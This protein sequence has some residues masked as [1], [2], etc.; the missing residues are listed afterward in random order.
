MN[1]DLLPSTDFDIIF[2]GGG[3]TACVAASRLAAADSNL[4]ILI[5]ENGHHTK[6]NPTHTQPGRY[7]HTM[8]SAVTAGTADTLTFHQGM[9]SANIDGRTPAVSS[10]KCVGGGSSINA[11][12]YNRAPA[13]DYD[14]WMHLG[15]AGWGS[16]DLIPLAKKLETYQAGVTNSTH[17][18][19]GPIKISYG[20]LETKLGKDFLVAA[21]G[22]PRGRG[23]TEDM[24]DFT[25]CDAYGRLPKYIDATT[26]RRSD[27]AHFYLYP[28]RGNPNFHVLD[29]ARV[30]RVLFNAEN[31]AIG[32]EYQ[33]ESPERAVL[34]ANAARLVVLSAGAFGSPAILER[35]GV[36]AKD[37]LEQHDITVI[38][39][40]PGVGENFNDHPAIFAPYLVPQ[41]GVTLNNLSQDTDG[42]FETQ[43]AH[44]GNGL[45]ATNGLDAGIKVR[46]NAQDLQQ[47]T[48]AFS[49]RWATFFADVPDKYVVF[50]APFSAH[51]GANSPTT[52]H[53]IFN[54][55]YFVPY[56]M[57]TG[58][59]HITSACP[60]A[61]LAVNTGLLD[62][63]EDLV[64]LRWAYKWSR[65]ITRR[66]DSYRGE[67]ADEHPVFPDGSQ[68]T[69]RVEGGPINIAAPE[70]E[71]S[72]ADD[73][74]IDA[75]HRQKVGLGWHSL[76]TCAMKPRDA[77]GVVDSRLSVYGVKNLKVAD[78]S[79][80]PLNVGANTNNTALIIGEKAAILIAED[81]GINGV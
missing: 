47:L 65:E 15:N 74:A 72:T 32:V 41:D 51:F 35:S 54:I 64:I 26:G 71:Y 18:S 12:L 2:V 61:P 43:W 38:S 28:Q 20:G 16:A 76:G 69:C 3:T 46:P 40:L 30:N 25:T 42:L 52:T 73:D 8:A 24:N 5:L 67:Y 66:M 10:A 1:I 50:V 36:G 19:S 62:R 57:S 45:M 29:H 48:P 55:L 56:P 59:V 6:D 4:R 21:A 58:A 22:F 7:R 37:W 11:M 53:A 9:P 78:M 70:I 49:T 23:F 39:D 68:A 81:L 77:S 14:D 31:V 44:E 27:V 79:I 17:G 13:S 80:A 60:F 75:Y 63:N 33:M 34:T